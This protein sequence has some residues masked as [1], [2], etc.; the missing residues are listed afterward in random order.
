MSKYLNLTEGILSEETPKEEII[1]EILRIIKE[2]KFVVVDD[3]SDK[4]WGMGYRFGDRHIKEFLE[5][6]FNKEEID[7]P[8]SSSLSP[9]FL[10][11][12]PHQKLSWQYHNRRSEVWKVIAGEVGTVTSKTDKQGPVKV[13]KEG[14][15]VIFDN[16]MRH[17]GVG[18]NSWGIIAEIWQHTDPDKLS[19]E[20]DIVRIGD[21]YGRSGTT[22][23]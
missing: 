11:I 14:D 17:R 3:M 23:R 21:E 9:K 10:I 6:F 20:E 22:E 7:I 12:A 16:K 18:L 13:H 15:I 4:P 1:K 5:T 2:L 8:E 19:D